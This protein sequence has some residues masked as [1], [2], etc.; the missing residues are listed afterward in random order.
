MLKNFVTPLHMLSKRN[1]INRMMDD[2][3]FCMNQAQKYEELYWDGERRFGYGGY[4]YIPGRWAPVA[5]ALIKNY[6]LGPDSTLLDVGCGKGFLL[7]EIKLILPEIK[8][9]GFDISNYAIINAHESV[10]QNL[11][12]HDAKNTYPYDDKYFDLTISLG[13]LHNL[14]INDLAASLSEIARVSRNQYIM[15]ESYRNNQELFNLQCWALT[16]KSFYSPNEWVWLFDRLGYRG[17][18]E[19]IYFE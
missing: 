19:F 13:V 14:A 2:K 11:F 7:N 12:V 6:S 5:E 8:I 17:D 10:K 1:Y 4:R 3:V 9:F 15:T 16:C 18:Y